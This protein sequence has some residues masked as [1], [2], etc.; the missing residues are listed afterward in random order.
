MKIFNIVFTKEIITFLRSFGLVAVVLYSFTL[1]IYIA[2]KG[3]QVK[4]RNVKIGYTDESEGVL[5]KKIL[6][7]FHKPE[8][9]EPIFF[10]SQKELREAIFEKEIIV[11]LIFDEDFEKNFIKNKRTKLNVLLDSTAATQS[12][13]TLSYLQEIVLNFF[14]FS[15]PIDLKIHKLFNQNADSKMFISFTE[16]LSVMT[17]LSVILTAVAFVKE[18]EEGTWDITLLMPVNSKI[19]ILAKVFSQVAIVMG[20]VVIA[21][22]FV[23]LTAFDTPLNGSFWAFM[24]LSL[25]YSFTS[26]GIGLF[27]AALSKSV[28]Q[29][30]Q[31]SIVIMMPLIFLSGAWT[32]IYSMNPFL[33]KLSLLSPLRYYI[34]GSESIFFR[35]TEF[36]DLWSYFLG[37]GVL[38]IVFFAVGYKKIGELF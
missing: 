23:V 22:G 19:V 28:V 25:L 6:S 14:S 38:S 37:V 30:A 9:K 34:E 36:V 35:G 26:A 2:G 18:K 17:L 33:Q 10:K 3:I 15:Q 21:L 16:L 13:I 27:I 20:G 24:L 7:H 31:L 1:D 11:G 8:F 29:V 32:P 12:Y 4:P 5:S